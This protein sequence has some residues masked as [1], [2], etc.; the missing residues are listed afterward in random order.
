MPNRI[1]ARR[2]GC[3]I[4][5]ALD[6]IGDRW[7]L[8]VIRDM[9]LFGKRTYSE[10]LD[11]EEGIATNVLSERLKRLERDG[12][13]VVAPDPTDARRKHYSLTPKGWDL[14]PVLVELALW[15]ARHRSDSDAPAGFVEKADDDRPG[16][17][18]WL[19]EVWS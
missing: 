3:P 10:F 4:G 18:A 5:L 6:I 19:M 17:M 2:S 15:T 7:T 13:I 12:T 14:V 1:P 11:S 16:L 8:L 9:A